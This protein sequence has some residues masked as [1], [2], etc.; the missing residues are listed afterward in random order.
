MPTDL[1]AGL[2]F[3]LLKPEDV[4]ASF[5]IEKQGNLSEGVSPSPS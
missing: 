1:P 2:F 5:E 3:D 4:E